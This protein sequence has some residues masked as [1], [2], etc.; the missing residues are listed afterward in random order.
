MLL[1]D[2]CLDNKSYLRVSG[3]V[4]LIVAIFHLYRNL[5]G[6]PLMW[7]EISVSPWF[8]WFAFVLTGYLSYS[9]F[10]LANSIGKANKIKRR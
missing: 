6:I 9:A 10:K 7:G 5:A 4:F 8:S 2:M 1:N 3:I